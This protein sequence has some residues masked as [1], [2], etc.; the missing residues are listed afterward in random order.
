MIQSEFWKSW[1]AF[2]FVAGP[3]PV[4]VLSIAV[5]FYI[6]N[7]HLDAMLDA[8]ENSRHIAI[9]GAGLRQQGWF[10]RV[11]LATKIGGVVF[12]FAGPNGRD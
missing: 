12:F 6:S 11:M 5:C 4:F 8:L 10:G 9:Y 7:R 3:F 1:W 2:V